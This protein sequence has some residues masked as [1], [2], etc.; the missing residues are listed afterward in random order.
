[1]DLF[2]RFEQHFEEYKNKKTGLINQL[3]AKKKIA[4]V[5]YFQEQVQNLIV[6]GFSVKTKPS[7]RGFSV[8]KYPAGI[9]FVGE[10]LDGQ[11]NGEGFLYLGEQVYFKGVFKL[12]Q[13]VNG[14]LMHLIS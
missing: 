9:Y 4:K 7:I 1:M 3:L 10:L 12:D 13:K 2:A 14:S 8:V 6:E 5:E 11:K